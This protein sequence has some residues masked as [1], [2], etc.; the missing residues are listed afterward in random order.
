MATFKVTFHPGP[1]DV[2]VDADKGPFA[3]VGEPGS[4]LDIALAHEVEIMHDCQGSG[5]CGT[6]CVLVEQGA[7][8]L[9]PKSEGESDTLESMTDNDPAARLACQAVVRGDVVVRIP[10]A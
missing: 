3:G 10:S 6:C 7:A 2:V 5:V 4:L 8:N 9:S 1:V